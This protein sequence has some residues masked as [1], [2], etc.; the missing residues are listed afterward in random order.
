[1]SRIRGQDTKPEIVV[2]KLL[3]AQGLRFRLHVKDLP[4]KPDIVLR[5]YK[6]VIMVNGCFWHRHQG[7]R[8]AYTPKSNEEFWMEKFRLNVER[9][10]R[11]LELLRS[12]GW[13]VELVWECETKSHEELVDRLMELF[14]K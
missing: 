7:C 2:R 9:D 10:A 12:A 6:T 3:H 5:K 8:F 14:L 1:M 11:N 13:R 4:R